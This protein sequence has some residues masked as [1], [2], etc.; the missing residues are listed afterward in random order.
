MYSYFLKLFI[1][2]NVYTKI[3]NFIFFGF[4]IKTNFF[5]KLKYG[6]RAIP[7]CLLLP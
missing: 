6:N 3:Q 1:Y 2:N 4:T 5:E 7:W